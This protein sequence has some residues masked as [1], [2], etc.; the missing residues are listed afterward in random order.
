MNGSLAILIDQRPPFP[1][2]VFGSEGT[3]GGSEHQPPHRFLGPQATLKEVQGS[4]DC[5]FN[6]VRSDV[7]LPVFGSTEAHHGG[8]V[9]DPVAAIH[10][11]VEASFLEEICLEY[12]QP[13]F[14]GLPK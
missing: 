1:F 5:R 8:H 9:E 14:M 7:I 12:P 13:G 4:L 6:D 3:N 2:T 11:L 10:G